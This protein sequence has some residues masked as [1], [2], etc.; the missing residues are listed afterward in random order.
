MRFSALVAAGAALS[1]F[2]VSVQAHHGRDFLLIQDYAVPPPLS[3]IVYGNFEVDTMDGPD[4][5]SIEPGGMIGLGRGLALGTSFHFTDEGG[6]W[7]YSSISP[8][9]QFQL[10]P[11]GSANPVKFAVLAGYQFVRGGEEEA[12]DHGPPVCGPEYGPDSPPCDEMAT[13]EHTHSHSHSG[14]HQHGVDAFFARLIME[15]DLTASDK[16]VVNLINV[17]PDGGDSSWGYAAGWRHS[18]NHDLAAGIETIGDF[19]RHGYHEA[20]LAGYYSPTHSCTLK[21][22][23]GAGLADE[24]PDFNF[25]TGVLWRF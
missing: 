19:N 12:H 5:W 20:V 16:L 7:E 17:T 1:A 21:I 24:S 22:G 23:A 13:A 9:V 2:A 4:E 15:T 14:I 3:G 6:G 25:R 11:Q 8:Q 10:T 18:F